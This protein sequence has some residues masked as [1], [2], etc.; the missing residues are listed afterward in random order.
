M[1]TDKSSCWPGNGPGFCR[2]WASGWVGGGRE[3]QP[4]SPTDQE[5]CATTTLLLNESVFT[6]HEGETHSPATTSLWPSE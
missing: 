2:M 1:R 4:V 5:S 3:S 6:R